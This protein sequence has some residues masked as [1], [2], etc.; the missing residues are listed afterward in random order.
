[1]DTTNAIKSA[2][3]IA[4]RFA[5][6]ALFGLCLGGAANAREVGQVSFVQGVTSA[7]SPGGQPRFLAKGCLLY[8][9]RCV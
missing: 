3:R 5:L 8:T 1:M 7:Q 9:S 6:G 4:R 2:A